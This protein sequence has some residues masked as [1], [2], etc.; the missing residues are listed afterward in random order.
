MI[1]NSA[2]SI[3]KTNERKYQRKRFLA[4]EEIDRLLEASSRPFR[5]L[6]I[7]AL[8]T[9]MRRGE[10]FNLRWADVDLGNCTIRVPDSK[11]DEPRDIPMDETLARELS[12][13]PTRFKRGYV[14]PSPKTGNQLTDL[15]RQFR[16]VVKKAKL[17]DVRF[18]DLRHT[19]ASHL[20][21]NGVDLKT[22]ATLLGHSTTRMSERYAHLSPDHPTRAV[23]VLDTAY[24]TDTKSDTVEKSGKSRSA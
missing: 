9:G 16:T 15:K 4:A 5:R 13:S 24:Q 21:M 14:F 7:T 19:F 6:L 12:S 2:G 17:S 22:V 18:H 3:K 10:I 1:E 23:K 8:H 11:T 20:V